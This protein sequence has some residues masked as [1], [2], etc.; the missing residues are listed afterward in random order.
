MEHSAG[1]EQESLIA[2]EQLVVGAV[3]DSVVEDLVKNRGLERGDV[4]AE[5]GLVDRRDRGLG[6]GVL[7]KA[8]QDAALDVEDFGECFSG[9]GKVSCLVQLA[10]VVL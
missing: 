4:E 1:V 3:R 8:G 2:G 7:G 5:R 6:V 9:G 10:R